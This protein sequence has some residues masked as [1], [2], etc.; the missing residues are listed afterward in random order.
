MEC[1][2]SPCVSPS[3]PSGGVGS[4]C[5]Q[6]EESERKEESVA[7][8]DALRRTPANLPL[9]PC[10]RELGRQ[11]G[12]GSEGGSDGGRDGGDG[13]G[14]E[15]VGVDGGDGGESGGRGGAGGEGGGLCGL[16]GAGGIG[17]ECGGS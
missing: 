14:D 15:G 8:G 13:G 2:W 10:Q 4:P 7:T 11:G 9:P 17:G 1:T 3:I 5:E 6:P 16:G 12:N